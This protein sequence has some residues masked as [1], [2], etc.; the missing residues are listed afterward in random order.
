MHYPTGSPIHIFPFIPPYPHA[1]LEEQQLY[2]PS[3]PREETIGRKKGV[4][5]LDPIRKNPIKPERFFIWRETSKRL[6]REQSLYSGLVQRQSFIGRN[7]SMITLSRP[8]SALRGFYGE[9][10]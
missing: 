6:E 3:P 7:R 2:S 10:I 5:G 4:H 8:Y 1:I 9:F